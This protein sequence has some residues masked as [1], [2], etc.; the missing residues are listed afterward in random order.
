MT[1]EAEN[2]DEDMRDKLS[3]GLGLYTEARTM[4]MSWMNA[5]ACLS[6]I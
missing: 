2:A 3:I 4:F 5:G 6:D 1:E